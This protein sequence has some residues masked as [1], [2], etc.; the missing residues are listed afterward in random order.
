MSSNYWTIPKISKWTESV[1]YFLHTFLFQISDGNVELG[2]ELFLEIPPDAINNTERL[3]VLNRTFEKISRLN[4]RF[5]K[6]LVEVP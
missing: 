1:K 3:D 6:S 5:N 2:L 4:E